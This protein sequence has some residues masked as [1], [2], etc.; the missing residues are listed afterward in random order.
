MYHHRFQCFFKICRET[1]MNWIERLYEL[2]GKDPYS[3]NGEGIYLEYIMYSL[4]L[5]LIGNTMF[6]IGGGDGFY[7]SNSKYLSDKGIS[8]IIFDRENN[9]NITLDNCLEATANY[10]VIISIDID[11][12]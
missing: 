4:D 8:N 10:H 6:D 5:P 11:G 2:K 7:L 3:Q 9:Y 12:N 1:K